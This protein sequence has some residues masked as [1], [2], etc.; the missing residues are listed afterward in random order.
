MFK[1]EEIVD[2]ESCGKFAINYG[3][4]FLFGLFIY[5]NGVKIE[6]PEECS[7][8][9]QRV[10]DVKLFEKYLGF[11]RIFKGHYF[12]SSDLEDRFVLSSSM[13]NLLGGCARRRRSGGNT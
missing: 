1:S 9:Q 13:R 10:K 7:E 4:L 12:K 6:H 11:L 8:Q 2:Q 3:P 5:L